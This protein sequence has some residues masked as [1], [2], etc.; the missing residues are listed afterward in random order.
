MVQDFVHSS[1][2]GVS[3][4]LVVVF[5]GDQ[6]QTSWSDKQMQAQRQVAHVLEANGLLPSRPGP[7]QHMRPTRPNLYPTNGPFCSLSQ[8]WLKNSRAKGLECVGS[9]FRSW[10]LFR[11]GSQG[12]PKKDIMIFGGPL[13]KTC[14]CVTTGPDVAFPVS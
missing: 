10:Y 12:R 2:F 7:H 9:F 14:P 6:S 13:K 8:R 4:C 3:L 11:G 1:S 5:F